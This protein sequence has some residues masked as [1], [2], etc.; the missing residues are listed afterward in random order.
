L[1]IVTSSHCLSALS[2]IN[3]QILTQF[4]PNIEIP[5]SLLSP[6]FLSKREFRLNQIFAHPEKISYNKPFPI[7]AGSMK[8]LEGTETEIPFILFISIQNRLISFNE[9]KPILSFPHSGGHDGVN[10]G[11]L[12]S[13]LARQQ[14]SYFVYSFDPV[15]ALFTL[16][17]LSPLSTV[18]S[19]SFILDLTKNFPSSASSSYSHSLHMVSSTGQAV[20]HICSQPSLLSTLTHP[21]PSQTC[22]LIGIQSSQS[23]LKAQVLHS[24]SGPHVSVIYEEDL[25]I[26]KSGSVKNILCLSSAASSDEVEKGEMTIQLTLVTP[27]SS[28]TSAQY[29]L[30]QSSF[31]SALLPSS[32]SSLSHLS[33]TTYLSKSTNSD[34]VSQPTIKLFLQTSPGLLMLFQQGRGVRWTREESLT[35]VRHGIIL[36]NTA[37]VLETE[38]LT[39]LPSLQKRLKMQF[40]D[41]KMKLFSFQTSFESIPLTVSSLVHENLPPQLAASLMPSFRPQKKAVD[42]NVDLFGF[43]KISVQLT[44]R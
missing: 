5:S 30:T 34:L 15:T 39:S 12:T 20:I 11:V 32:S 42:V 10:G 17:T 14:E 36:D 41:L 37:A 38:G 13:P 22:V 35:R 18:P 27:P 23:A 6:A 3:G 33:F 7:L 19:T 44:S 4:C 31:T 26:L 9:L 43:N 1:F 21:S 8:D 40:E 25:S 16:T 2:P 24:C 28:P 29:T